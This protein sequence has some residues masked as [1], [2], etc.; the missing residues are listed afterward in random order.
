MMSELDNRIDKF[1]NIARQPKASVP[2]SMKETGKKAFGCFPIYTPE[3]IIYAA[4]LLP[5]G[6]WGGKTR[7]V[8]A[9]KYIQGFCC[10][11]MRAN[12]ELGIKCTYDFLEGI[13]I[14]TYCDSMKAILANWSIAVPGCKAIPFVSPQNRNSSFSLGFLISQYERFKKDLE[15]LTGREITGESIEKSFQIYEE[16][17]AAMRE[18]VRLVN[19]YPLTLTPTVRHLIIKAAYFTDKAAYT[20]ELRALM[21][22]LKEMPK[23]K[24]KGPKV[25]IT[26]YVTEPEALLDAFTENGYVIA[27]DDLAHES[28][29]FRT[30]S[31]SEGTAIEK[32]AYRMID[33]R[34]CTFFYEENK[35]RGAMLADFVKEYKAD[36]VVAGVYKFCDPEEFDYPVYKKELEEKKIPVLYIEIDQQAD[37][38]EQLRTRIQGFAETLSY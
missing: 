7:I 18:F 34:G 6:M 30:L 8:Q 15:E 12:L 17:R 38:V 32:M 3:E 28:R 20:K 4:S 33:L 22:E 26:G 19:E 9:D 1:L 36:G 5:V 10:T 14:P 27:A 21:T 25:I 37:S 24:A 29:Q 35:S 31:R 16:Y 11:I 23:E 13:I 2:A